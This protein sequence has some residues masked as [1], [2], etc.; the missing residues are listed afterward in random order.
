MSWYQF[1]NLRVIIGKV[2][3]NVADEDLDWRPPTGL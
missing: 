3:V 1:Q 2:L